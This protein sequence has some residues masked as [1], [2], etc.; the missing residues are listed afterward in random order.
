MLLPTYQYFP[1]RQTE[2]FIILMGLIPQTLHTFHFLVF[3]AICID[4]SAGSLAKNVDCGLV[5]IAL[6]LFVLDKLLAAALLLLLHQL[7]W[8]CIYI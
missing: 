6:V 1:E 3:F 5:S 4:T 7:R 2:H 8:I